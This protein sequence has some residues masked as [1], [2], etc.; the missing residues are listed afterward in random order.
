MTVRGYKVGSQIVEDTH[1]SM[2]T[3]VRKIGIF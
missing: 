2:R 1:I 3:G